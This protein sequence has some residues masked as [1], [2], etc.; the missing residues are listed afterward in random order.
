MRVVPAASAR[1]TADEDAAL[2]EAV[3]AR[4]PR[5]PGL[6]WDR[7]STLARRILVRSLGPSV[8]V[9]DALQDVFL[10]LFRD[11]HTLREPAAL[12]SFI[13][14]ITLHVA[15]SELRKR[16][17][18]RWLLLWNDKPLPEVEPPSADGDADQREAL[19]RLYSILD[20]IDTRRRLVFVLRFVEGVELAEMSAIL[21]CS[22][23]TTKRRVADAA[24]RVTLLAA[25]DPLLS[26][27]VTVKS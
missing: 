11:L 26:A 17:A 15:T 10:R 7:Y 25:G 13:I 9:E 4:A 3:R 22:L 19:S 23:A 20:R 24:R 6:L 21:E 18:R 14:G 8:D 2:V 1:S 27:Y 5:A 16:R 12:R